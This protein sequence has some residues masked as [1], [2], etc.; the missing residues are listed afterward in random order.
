[1]KIQVELKGFTPVLD[2]L[3]QEYDIVTAAIY[4]IV[5]RYAQMENRVCNASL[6]KIGE[7]LDMSGKTAER[8]IKKLCDDG[9][10]IDRTPN[11]RNKPH[12]YEVTGKAELSG[13]IN[14][15]SDRES[16]QGQTESLTRSD[17]ESDQGQTESPLKKDTKKH[18]K[19]H[20][21]SSVSTDFGNP[22]SL[23]SFKEIKELKLPL[24]EWKQY[25]AD[26]KAGRHRAGVIKFLENKVATGPLLP[27][28]EAAKLLFAKLA[29]EAEAKSRRPPQK[30]PTLAC[31]EKF[32]LAAGR[33]NGTLETAIDN[34]LAAGITAIPKLVN[35]IS[36]PKWA[37]GTNERPRAGTTQGGQRKT[38][39]T[40]GQSTTDHFSPPAGSGQTP[41]MA[42]RL[43][44]HFA[45]R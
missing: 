24:K 33:L 2:I 11:V 40:A 16:D 10:L 41:E 30:F 6:K 45:P 38:Y 25:L 31:K 3:I 12:T 18:N 1:M 42:A 44:A 9:Y 19:K 37:E 43:R 8:H 5:W 34:G 13:S 21:A 7:R 23:M 22:V 35:Y 14:T 27:D 4:G 17:R 28:T 29:I 39:G 36:S 20:K 15:R 32:A 26:E